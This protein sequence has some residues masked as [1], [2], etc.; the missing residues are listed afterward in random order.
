MNNKGHGAPQIP[1]FVVAI[2]MAILYMIPF[3]I[4]SG[5]ISIAHY[6]GYLIG[7]SANKWSFIITTILFCIIFLWTYLQEKGIIK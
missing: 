7:H 2:V 4:I 6:F 5:G 1:G 3:S